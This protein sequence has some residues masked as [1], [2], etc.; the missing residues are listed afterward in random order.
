MELHLAR[1]DH[2]SKLVRLCGV[3][4]DSP[5]VERCWGPLVGPSVVALIRRT[6][7]LTAQ[8]GGPARIDCRDMAQLL[9]LHASEAPGRN[10]PIGRTM[11]RAASFRLATADLDTGTFAIHDTVAVL[12]LR[13]FRRL[14][15]W[16]KDQHLV[17]IDDVVGRLRAAGVDPSVLAGATQLRNGPLP[18]QRGDATR[19]RGPTAWGAERGPNPGAR[20]PGPGGDRA[21]RPS[22]RPRSDRSA[23]PERVAVTR[24]ALPPTPTSP[25]RTPARRTGPHNPNAPTRGGRR[26]RSRRHDSRSRKHD[27]SAPRRADRPMQVHL[28]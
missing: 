27:P 22:H 8:A 21:A 9:G 4:P 1:I 15:Y 5:Y 2:P 10:N 16:A 14:P 17:V 7:E 13:Q 20:H 18:E 3:T 25:R 26:G 6:H 11:R 28:R 23:T 19:A 12:T 24:P